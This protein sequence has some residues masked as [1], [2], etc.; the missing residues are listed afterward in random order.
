MTVTIQIFKIWKD[1]SM[2]LPSEELGK[3]GL[4][5]MLITLIHSFYLYKKGQRKWISKSYQLK[6]V[7]KS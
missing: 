5:V 3:K 1:T 6:K 7:K 4:L 2:F